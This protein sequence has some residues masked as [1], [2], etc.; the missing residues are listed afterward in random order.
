M[1]LRRELERKTELVEGV[2]K[3]KFDRVSLVPLELPQKLHLT[4]R[5]DL[6]LI[7]ML[8]SQAGKFN[9]LND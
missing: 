6:F 9:R 8:K 2:G 5:F 3:G 7:C 1:S 4:D